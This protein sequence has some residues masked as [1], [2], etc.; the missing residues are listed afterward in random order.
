[1]FGL[2][3]CLPPNPYISLKSLNVYELAYKVVGTSLDLCQTVQANVNQWRKEQGGQLDMRTEVKM[4]RLPLMGW[5]QPLDVLEIQTE[6]A[7]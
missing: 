2:T 4:L 5:E 3:C 6:K 7:D 1:M